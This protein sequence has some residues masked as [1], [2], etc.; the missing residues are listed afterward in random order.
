LDTIKKIL[1]FRLSSIGDI[2]L[3]TALVRCLKNRY[4]NAQIDFVVKKQFRQ[5]VDHNPHIHTI[6]TVDSSEGFSGL[7][8]LKAKIRLTHYDVFIDI[9]KNIRSLFVRSG[10][11]AKITLTYNKHIIKR[12]IL[13]NIGIDNYRIVTPVYQ[14]FIDAAKKID[15]SYDGKGTELFIGA[16]IEEKIKRELTSKNLLGEKPYI[17]LCPGA[18]FKNKQWLPEQFAELANTLLDKENVNVL[19][20]GGAAEEEVCKYIVQ[21]TKGRAI[22]FSVQLSILESGVLAKYAKVVVAN[23]TGMLHIAEALKVP[24][25]GI[26]G[27]TTRQFGYF[28]ILENSQVVEIELPCRPCTKMGSNNCPK[29]HWKCMKNITTTMVYNKIKLL[30]ARQYD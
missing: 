1:L 18:S 25:I 29:K 14:R 23:D 15:V 30:I 17:L 21:E 4:P 9:H 16:E 19:L 22:D 13:T 3:T 26:Y 5:L 24:V 20:V 11:G 10:S 7:R 8:K 2:V 28:P 12:T 6:Y 27:P